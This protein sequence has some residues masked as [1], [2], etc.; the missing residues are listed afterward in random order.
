M[1]FLND[2]QPRVRFIQPEN[3][4]LKGKIWKVLCKA[5]RVLREVASG[6]VGAVSRA[7]PRRGRLSARA[8]TREEEL[9]GCVP[10][11]QRLILLVVD[12]EWLFLFSSLCFSLGPRFSAKTVSCFCNQNKSVI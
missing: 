1:Y 5:I 12:E 9:A 8:E 3:N 4:S 10:A 7:G 2:L 11:Q 6:Q